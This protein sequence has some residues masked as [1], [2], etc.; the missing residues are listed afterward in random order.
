MADHARKQ[1]RAAA[2]S[3][4]TGNALTGS[5]VFNAR[6][7]PIREADMPCFNVFLL[8]ETS[9]HDAM[10]TVL[11]TGDLV[12]EGR[13]FGGDDIFDKLDALAAEAERIIYGETPALAGLLQNI[14]TPRTQIELTDPTQGSERRTGIIRVLFPVQYR[15]LLTDPTAI[16]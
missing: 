13:D 8:D 5:D 11:R 14:G 12:V 2:V 16:V 10:T 6:V 7:S 3:D 4:L 15:T 9:E 1:V